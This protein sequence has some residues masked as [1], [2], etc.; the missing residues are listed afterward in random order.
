[1]A[2]MDRAWPSPKGMPSRAQ[3]SASQVPRE[4]AFGRDDEPCSRGRNDFQ[5]GLRARL[6]MPVHENLAALVEDTDVHGTGMQIDAAITR[7]WL[8][9][10]APE[11]L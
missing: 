7:V 3:R 1:M 11:I 9:V 2:F 4:Q 6:H 5:K 10:E 8:G